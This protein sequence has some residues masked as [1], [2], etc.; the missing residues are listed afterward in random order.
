MNDN[1]YSTIMSISLWALLAVFAGYGL[2][3]MLIDIGMGK[4]G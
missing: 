4:Y 2:G 3:S 1:P